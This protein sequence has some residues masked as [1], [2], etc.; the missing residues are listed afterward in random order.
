MSNIFVISQKSKLSLEKNNI[1]LYG[2]EKRKIPI[3][4]VENIFIF[5]GLSLDKKTINILH[6]KSVYIYWINKYGNITK[7]SIPEKKAKLL[8]KTNAIATYIVGK[9]TFATANFIISVQPKNRPVAKVHRRVFYEFIYDYLPDVPVESL[10]VQY[11]SNTNEIYGN[12][13]MLYNISFTRFYR[14]NNPIN[15][16][17]NM[18]HSL[19]I[20]YLTTLLHESGFDIKQ[21]IFMWKGGREN[22]NYFPLPKAFFSFFRIKASVDAVYVYKHLLNP[23]SHFSEKNM[24]KKEGILLFAK[25]FTEKFVHNFKIHK[26]LEEILDIIEALDRGKIS[27]IQ[28]F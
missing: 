21:K 11:I 17:I 7:I 22:K 4:K 26:R 14:T 25:I 24:L 28:L 23:H 10:K 20:A 27:V 8:K 18:L 13:G 19:T 16:S 5:N 9:E 1:I 15:V 12:I 6:K 2:E 3:S